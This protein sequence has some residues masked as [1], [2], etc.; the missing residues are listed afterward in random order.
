MI[1]K[2]KF[3]VFP[4]WIQ[5]IK[6]ALIKYCFESDRLQAVRKVGANEPGFSR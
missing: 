3:G 1:R 6:E 4:Y 2:N 5:L